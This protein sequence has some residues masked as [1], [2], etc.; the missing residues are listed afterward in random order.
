MVQ[1]NGAKG[2]PAVMEEE[3]YLVHACLWIAGM[4]C[5]LYTAWYTAGKK[6]K[7]DLGSSDV[8]SCKILRRR[9]PPPAI[10]SPLCFF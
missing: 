7:C 8:K 1:E 2:R 4:L 10:H 5:E 9:T 3:E 6:C